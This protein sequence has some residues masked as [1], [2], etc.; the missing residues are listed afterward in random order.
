MTYIPL[1]VERISKPSY[2]RVH[3]Y[4]GSSLARKGV[5]RIGRQSYGGAE[6]ALFLESAMSSKPV[7]LDARL[8]YMQSAYRS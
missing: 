7:F 1:L 5:L 3:V 4:F 6:I 8:P 2:K